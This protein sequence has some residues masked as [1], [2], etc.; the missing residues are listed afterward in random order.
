MGRATTPLS[1]SKIKKARPREK[2]YKLADG[3]GLY[4]YVLP[5]GRKR[6][7][8]R[9]RHEGENLE[10]TIGDYPVIS[11][12]EA[13]KRAQ[14]LRQMIRDGIDPIR[15][16]EEKMKSKRRSSCSRMWLTCFFASKSVN[17]AHHTFC[18]K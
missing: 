10:Y 15:A 12:S 17:T 16:K 14:E 5:S 11:L 3:N 7:K 13:R 2:R 9:Y 1:D 18:A 4:L 6:W 8:L